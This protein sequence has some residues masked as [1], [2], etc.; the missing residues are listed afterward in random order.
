MK[1]N[2][3]KKLMITMMMLTIMMMMSSNNIM[4][5]W[6]TLEINT[7][8][9]MNI[10]TNS[11]KSTDQPMKYF[12]I[13]SLSSSTMLMSIMINSIAS[14][15]PSFKTILMMSML[16]KLGMMPFHS[17]LPTIMQSSNWETCM[18]LMTAQKISPTIMMTQMIDV[19]SMI[20]PMIFSLI[21]API[22]ATKQLAM[23]KIL[24][25]SSIS[26]MS[27]MT[28]AAK[29]SKLN[30]IMFMTIYTTITITLIKSMETKKIMYMN[31]MKM[32]N[33]WKKMNMLVNM[34]S[35]SG[36]PP[37]MG[38][39]PKWII[40][41][42]SIQQ[43]IYISI[44]FIISSIILTFTYMKMINPILASLT[45]KKKKKKENKSE[46]SSLIMNLMGMPMNFILKTN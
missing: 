12:I 44:S 22:S 33:K 2:M 42:N 31:Q 9:F 7:I 4:Y 5:S 29:T 32:H 16:M 41:Q 26:N 3:T 8:V 6:M 13:Q 25:Y 34:I 38:F 27:W 23:K 40:L 39:F 14:I 19:K 15:P 21:I 37:T 28:Y 10:L 17:W 1:I 35:M 43:S 20:L 11:K 36:M 46:K 45:M 30:F 18:L 24:A